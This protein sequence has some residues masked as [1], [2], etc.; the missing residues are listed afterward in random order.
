MRVHLTPALISCCHSSAAGRYTCVAEGKGGL[1]AD[2]ATIFVTEAASSPDTEV[3]GKGQGDF[4]A[5]SRYTL[6]TSFTLLLVFPAAVSATVLSAV[7]VAGLCRYWRIRRM[8]RNMAALTTNVGAVLKHQLCG[9]AAAPLVA[10]QLGIVETC[11]SLQPPAGAEAAEA[12]AE[13]C[14]LFTLSSTTTDS[15]LGTD[16][17]NFTM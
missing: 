14:S 3:G 9:D 8:P 16:M 11:L 13:R 17:F 4:C 12:G 7:I 5:V 1:A 10:T 2:N 15:G 6:Q